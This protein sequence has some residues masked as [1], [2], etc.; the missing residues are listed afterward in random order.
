MAISASGE[1][2]HNRMEPFLAQVMETVLNYVQWWYAQFRAYLEGEAV[3]RFYFLA[4][5][6]AYPSAGQAQQHPGG[7]EQ[8]RQ[9]PL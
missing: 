4:G 1:G 3:P 6:L 2:Y 8:L 5:D 9:T 7:A